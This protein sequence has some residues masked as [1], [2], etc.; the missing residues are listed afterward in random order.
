MAGVNHT[1]NAN[2]HGCQRASSVVSTKLG[3]EA[4]SSAAAVIR[5]RTN[6][7]HG[8]ICCLPFSISTNPSTQWLPFFLLCDSQS[9]RSKLCPA[10][11]RKLTLKCSPPFFLVYVFGNTELAVLH[12]CLTR[13]AHLPDKVAENLTFQ[14]NS[15]KLVVGR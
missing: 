4:T 10:A 5:G 13:S 14:S 6:Q 3:P 9:L 8:N 11:G 2:P 15:S 12:P 7:D 1:A